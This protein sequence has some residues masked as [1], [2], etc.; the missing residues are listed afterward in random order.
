[1]R[2][3]A[4]EARWRTSTS[5]QLSLLAYLSPYRPCT[6]VKTRLCMD[7]VPSL[8]AVTKELLRGRGTARHSQSLPSVSVFRRMPSRVVRA[9]FLSL[10]AVSRYSLLIKGRTEV[11]SPPPLLLLPPPLLLPYARSLPKGLRSAV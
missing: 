11:G 5:V 8:P 10:P 7:T 9:A 2:T 6:V 3:R 1:M 4:S